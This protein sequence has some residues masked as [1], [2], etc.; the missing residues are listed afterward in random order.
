MACRLLP[1]TQFHSQVSILSGCMVKLRTLD[2]STQQAAYPHWQNH[3]K[4]PNY[5]L[6]QEMIVATLAQQQFNV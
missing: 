1:V 6:Y 5:L 3:S 2:H 4:N